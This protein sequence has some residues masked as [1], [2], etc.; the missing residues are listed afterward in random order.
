MTAESRVESRVTSAESESSLESL[1]F[2][3]AESRVES[4]VISFEFE[5]SRVICEVSRV[6][7]RVMMIVQLLF[8][9]VIIGVTSK[10]KYIINLII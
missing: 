4:R 9:S 5:S 6:M 10:V 8:G 7:S 3:G 2:L 1:I